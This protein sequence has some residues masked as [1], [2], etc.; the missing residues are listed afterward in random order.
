MFLG[1][2]RGANLKK[3]NINS[4]LSP[5]M[6]RSKNKI[7]KTL[8]NHLHTIYTHKIKCKKRRKYY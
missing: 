2:G 5:T 4:T 7:K 8:I 3:I 1:R 6:S